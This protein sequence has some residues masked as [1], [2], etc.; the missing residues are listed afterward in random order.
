[1]FTIKHS[2]RSRWSG[3]VEGGSGEFTIGKTGTRLP[4]TL[5]SRMGEEPATNPEELVGAAVAGCYAMS[6]AN[7]LGDDGT[8]AE[9]VEA[10]ATVHLVRGETGF[11]VPVIELVVTASG[12]ALSDAEFQVVAA[13][14]KQHCPISNLMR[15]EVRLSASLATE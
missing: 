9:H 12:L 14:A 2:S 6:L 8:P 4:F 11:S 3:S 5:R 15:A 10:Q 13:R 7:E 1:M